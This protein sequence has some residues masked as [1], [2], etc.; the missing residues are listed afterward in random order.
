[1][2]LA[3]TDGT[4]SPTPRPHRLI[5]QRRVLIP[6]GDH[7]AARPR[8][9]GR[10]TSC[11]CCARSARNKKRLRRRESGVVAA[12]SRTSRTRR[13]SG[14]PPGSRVST[15]PLPDRPG[16]GHGLR[17]LAAGLDPLERDEQPLSPLSSPHPSHDQPQFTFSVGGVRIL[18]TG[19]FRPARRAPRARSARPG[20]TPSLALVR[21]PGRRPEGVI[22]AVRADLTDADRR[23]PGAVAAVAARCRDRAL[24]RPRRCR[25]LRARALSCAAPRERG[26]HARNLAQACR[27]ERTAPAS[28]QSPPTSSSMA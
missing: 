1:M 27:R 28:S 19:G 14:V 10:T 24:R 17:A 5:G 15:R 9:P 20:T 2:R 12:S 26:R 3:N 13:P 16:Q 23:G 18:I 22:P 7:H 4:R 21:D 8:A 25:G 6:V 11:R